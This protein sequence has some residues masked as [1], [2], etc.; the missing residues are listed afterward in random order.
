MLTATTQSDT[1]SAA[2]RSARNEEGGADVNSVGRPAPTASTQITDRVKCAENFNVLI[3]F[4][5]ITR[6]SL[7]LTETL[8]G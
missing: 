2:G 3:T 8:V 1:A 7:F 4:C 6:I 5:P